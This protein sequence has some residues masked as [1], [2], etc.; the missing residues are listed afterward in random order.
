MQLIQIVL[1]LYDNAG[2][3]HPRSLFTETVAELTDTF[4]GA[5]AFTRSPAEG[6]WENPEG[7]VQRDDVIV[8]EVMAE[9]IDAAWWAAS[10]QKLESRFE[11]QSVLIRALPC[12]VL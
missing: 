11:Q 3:R 6:F 9:Q 7:R 5:T 12:R 10:R 2:N 8:I 4:G 1:P